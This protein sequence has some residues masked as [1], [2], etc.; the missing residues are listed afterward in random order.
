[1]MMVVGQP[2]ILYQGLSLPLWKGKAQVNQRFIP[3]CVILQQFKSILHKEFQDK[4]AFI[5][6]HVSNH[7]ARVRKGTC[8]SY[9]K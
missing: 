7:L 2:N 5:Q 9:R 4:K 8:N 3:Y 6:I 1:M